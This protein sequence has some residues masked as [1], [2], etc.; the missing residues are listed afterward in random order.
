RI[1]T[2]FT[3]AGTNKRIDLIITDGTTAL[4]IEV[5]MNWDQFEHKKVN[6]V[7]REREA[8]TI[9]SRF[10]SL[11]SDFKSVVHCKIVII[12]YDLRQRSN[13]REK[14][15]SVFSRSPNPVELVAYSE[16]GERVVRLTLG[17]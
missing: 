6:G 10:S 3:P 11:Q 5:K 2:E 4:P 13:R 12:Q 17:A 8:S 14:A 7:M 15:L 1:L 16:H 9:V